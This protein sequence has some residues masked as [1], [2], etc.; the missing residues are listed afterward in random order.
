LI[1]TA[2]ALPTSPF[3]FFF[4][5]FRQRGR[6]ICS[7]VEAG[8]TGGHRFR[9]EQHLPVPADY[10]SDSETRWLKFSRNGAVSEPLAKPG[11]TGVVR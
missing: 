11:I 4:F 9:R 1:T 7:A 10:D 3:F 8:F 2:T 6:G 5:F